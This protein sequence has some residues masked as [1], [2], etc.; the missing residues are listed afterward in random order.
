MFLLFVGKWKH[1]L[2]EEVGDVD[3]YLLRGLIIC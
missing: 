1:F 2:Y 3:K